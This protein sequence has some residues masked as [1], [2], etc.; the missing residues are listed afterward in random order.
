MSF[1]TAF[2]KVS[3]LVELF[4][5]NE[6]H[7]LESKY[8]ES[9]ARKDF[10]DKFW[11]AL[12]W[13]VHHDTQTNPREQE[14]KIEKNSDSFSSRKADYAFYLAPNYSRPQ[15]LVEA[16][17]PSA[18][19]ADQAN[20]FQTARYG[21]NT[22][23][24][25]AV[26]TSFYEFH[27]ID[28]RRVPT[29]VEGIVQYAFLQ[30]FAYTEYL[31][32]DKFGLI[33]WTFS[34]EAVEL[35]KLKEYWKSLPKPKGK[36]K[37]LRVVGDALAPVDDAFLSELD[38][39]RRILAS[40]FKK[41]NASLSAEDLTEAA[42]KVL[43]RLVFIRFLED[44]MIE[45]DF[46]ID[47]FCIK[48]E[49]WKRFVK[50]S[51]DLDKNYN[52]VVFKEHFID[53]PDFKPPVDAKFFDICKDLSH[54][55]SPY[56]FSYIPVEILGSIYERFLGK[57]VVP[58]GRGIAVEEKPEVRKAGGVYYT[59]KYIVDYIV[60]NTVGKIL[61][62][63]AKEWK[64]PATGMMMGV[65][66]MLTP[67]Q[68]SK[69]R[70]A[71]IAC[72]SGSFLIAVFDRIVHHN[73]RYY[74]AH[75]EEAKKAKCRSG[76]GNTWVLS[77]E[78]KRRVLQEN[79]YGVD[80]DHQAVEVAQFSLFLKLLESET[81]ATTQASQTDL[82]L[83]ASKKILP[84]LS[85]NI[86]CGNSLVDYD[87]AQLFP[88]TDAEEDK[89]KPFS[90]KQSFKEIL[91]GGGFDAILGNPPYGGLLVDAVKKYIKSHFTSYQFKFDSYIYF[92]ERALT[93]TKNGGYV[94]YITPEH[95]L[96]LSNSDNLRRY[97]L[98]HSHFA[99]LKIWGENV[100]A[101]A[102]V[103]TVTFRL[104]KAGSG[105]NLEIEFADQDISSRTVSIDSIRQRPGLSIDFRVSEDVEEILNKILKMPTLEKLGETIQGI[106]P[107]DK[108]RGQS[109]DLIKSRA[110]HSN[111]QK[112]KSYGKW[113]AGGDL[114]R[115]SIT[116]SGEWLSYGPWL[117]AARDPRFFT[118][119]R[120]LFREIPGS[121]KRIQ[122][123]Y[124]EETFY[125]GHSITPFLLSSKTVD[126][127]Y[128]LGIV[129][130]N[131]L[132]W[133]GRYKLSNFGKDIFP[134]LNPEDIKHLPVITFDAADVKSKKLHDEIV[135]F[136]D[137]TLEVKRRLKNTAAG[138]QY[139]QLQRKCD[140]LDS[141]ID[142]VVYE[143]YGLTEE[144]IETVEAKVEKRT[145]SNL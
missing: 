40:E 75:P 9:E 67:A 7:Y 133:F 83:G 21:Y 138:A 30:K 58:K 73:E 13:D 107:Y 4:R 36:T 24:T 11:I 61:D 43:D 50:A 52:G 26:L 6:A 135:A 72:G 12:G 71:D 55:D 130:S 27:I 34:R 84:D 86:L 17:K 117:A 66:R 92:I 82:A 123:A 90:F 124:A 74:N 42:Q 103:S 112:N 16:K 28:C 81:I 39:Y 139:D 44:K 10:I 56:L 59:P 145:S 142:R 118:G 126:I 1:D 54:N 101:A 77:L 53:R 121:G 106:T 102:V 63:V 120:L 119:P 3:E 127:R 113:L 78:Q 51:K 33:Y 76:E 129:N 85:G 100:F 64:D 122:T 15:F 25:V 69:L 109:A 48:G 111:K 70:F 96:R 91:G 41:A 89:I 79:I 18:P 114:S 20:Y 104:A 31:D 115:Y 5:E 14:V 97:V 125:H 49:S 2:T 128:V 134:K 143:L 87:I 144:E 46:I 45:P 60:E 29:N 8:Q 137:Q 108:Y 131:L 110:F 23:T 19:L 32:R 88:L 105:P 136:V 68:V 116:W 22:S 132:S 38:E 140:Y 94:S 37:Q 141:E 80:I 65:G 93:L 98:D 47:G 35:G 99:Q 57:I 62:G 95:W